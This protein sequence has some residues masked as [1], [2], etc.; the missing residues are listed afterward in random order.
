MFYFALLPISVFIVIPYW[1]FK[2]LMSKE[3]QLNQ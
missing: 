3:G 1:I 2:E